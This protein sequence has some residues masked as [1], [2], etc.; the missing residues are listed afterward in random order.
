MAEDIDKINEVFRMQDENNVR[1]KDGHIKPGALDEYKMTGSGASKRKARTKEKKSEDK[2][3]QNEQT[4]KKNK[5]KE[6]NHF[7][8]NNY[9]KTGCMGGIMY[10][11]FIV[12]I[13]VVIA[14]LLW[15]AA[16]DFMALN[17]PKFET[18]VTLP[19][20]IFTSE[21]VDTFDEEGNKTG[22]KRISVADTE[23]VTKALKDAGLIDYEWL[24]NFF[25]DISNA[26]VK[27]SP[28]E[29]EL[30]S[31]YDYRALIQH[32]R[33]G[34]D[35]ALTVDVTIPEGFTMHQ[36]FQ[37]LDEKG[38]C[39]YDE[40]VEAA[41]NYKYNYPFLEG[42]EPGSSQR[43]EGYL[44]PETYQFYIDMQGSSAINKFLDVFYMKID[45]DILA[46][47]NNMGMSLDDVLK[48]ASMIEKEAANDNERAMIASVIY[49][50]LNANMPLGIDATI[51][52][53]YPDH[54]GAPTAEMLQKD[55]PY[56]SRM[57]AG[58]PPTPIANPGL[59]SIKAALNPAESD[60]YYYALDTATGEHRFFTNAGEHE[61]FVATQNYE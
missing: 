12:C 28:G 60:Y 42:K 20:E 47:C 25:C 9:R 23:Y 2:K 11:V 50:R 54:E 24:F 31:S 55:S 8:S 36:I 7:Q 51:L 30:K 35:S 57:Y 58:L 4:G 15:M 16:S 59:A 18:K 37:R 52:Y 13:S 43:L 56:N 5:S 19:A 27:L 46:Q 3:P 53:E 40:L 44:F 17:K 38:V 29:Y 33:A 61:A 6:D 22:T 41:A 45:A 1:K 34:S 10:F 21:T 26:E 48:V 49:N 32:M 39:S 14:C